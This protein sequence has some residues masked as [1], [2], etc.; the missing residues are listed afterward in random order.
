MRCASSLMQW[1]TW[2]NGERGAVAI[3]SQSV[4]ST[5]ALVRY[6]IRH[7]MIKA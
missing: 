3:G 6:A 2:A 4:S 1:Y 5:A 7:E